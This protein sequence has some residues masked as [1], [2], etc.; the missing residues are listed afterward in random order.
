MPSSIFDPATCAAALREASHVI[1]AVQGLPDGHALIS[2]D[3][4]QGMASVITARVPAVPTAEEF[5]A[6]VGDL[7]ALMCVFVAFHGTKHPPEET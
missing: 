1:A 2:N 4:V 3:V 6:A 7:L 5:P